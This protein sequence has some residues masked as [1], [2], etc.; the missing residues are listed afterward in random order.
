MSKTVQEPEFNCDTC[1]NQYT[2]RSSLKRHMQKVHDVTHPP[3]VRSSKNSNENL[4]H[5]RGASLN[6]MYVIINTQVE[7][8]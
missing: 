1:S 2:L 4:K 6:V 5:Q 3:K 8:A 7:G